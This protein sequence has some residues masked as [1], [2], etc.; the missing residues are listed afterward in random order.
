MLEARNNRRTRHRESPTALTGALAHFGLATVLT[1]LD[2]ERRT[3]VLELRG[4]ARAGRISFR[5]GQVV[6]AEVR[7]TSL[8]GLEAVCELMSWVDGG[9]I[10]RVA[11]VGAA[12]EVMLP[13]HQLLM[14]V[15]RRADELAA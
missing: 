8:R 10:F 6:H 13:T 9:F 15:A 14:E 7:D 2:M 4:S 3:G 11:E 1:V 12:D 5:D